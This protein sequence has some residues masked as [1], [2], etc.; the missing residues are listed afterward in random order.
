M[1]HQA[2][3]K[4]PQPIK[5]EQ[6]QSV[7]LNIFKKFQDLPQ[8]DFSRLNSTENSEAKLHINDMK[9]KLKELVPS[10]YYSRLS[11]ELFSLGPIE[12]LTENKNISE[13]IINGKNHIFYEK[14]G[15]LFFL[16]DTFLSDLTFHNCIHKIL[17]EA[18]I[19]INLKKPFADGSWRG[20]RIHIT[21]H[22]IVNVDFHLSLRKHPDSP[23]T[24]SKLKDQGWAPEQAIQT[25]QKVLQEKNN[26]LIVGPTSSGKTSVLNAC[27][28]ALPEKERI[29]SI[30]DS[31]ELIL[32]NSFSTKLF[33]RTNSNSP[34]T[35]L[36]IDQSELVRQSLRMR[37]D[38]I[39]MGEARGPEAKDLL[40]A[41]ATGHRGSLGT[42]HA[43]NHTQAL[44]RLEMLVQMGAPSW[45]THT[46]RQ[47]IK[48]SIECLI[49]LG[50]YRG[51]RKLMGIH[52]LTGLEQTG[53]L[54]ETLFSHLSQPN[55]FF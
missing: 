49:V 53:F 27:L 29:I 31:S 4:T 37:P 28:Q 26:L 16:E 19:L 35:L 1:T 39:I 23:W 54:F 6:L 55:A 3:L 17:E 32:P 2:S 25:I 33:T 51:E 8:V 11:A 34:E 5:Q 10:Q 9:E 45:N 30:E 52:K 22:P 43:T 40:M 15:E 46:I 13:I 7:F 12:K 50:H 24:F 38:R 36:N 21:S 41:L 42:I 20:W 44:W 47:M 48:L 14:K 18:G